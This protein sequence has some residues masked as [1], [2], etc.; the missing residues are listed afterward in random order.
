MALLWT[1]S[2]ALSPFC[3]GAEPREICATGATHDDNLP[4]AH[5]RRSRVTWAPK[6]TSPDRPRTAIAP[7]PSAPTASG[8]PT[9]TVFAVG[10]YTSAKCRTRVPSEAPAYRTVSAQGSIAHPQT[11]QPRLWQRMW[12]CSSRGA[13]HSRSTAPY[14]TCIPLFSAHCC[15]A[16]AIA[17]PSVPPDA[18]SPHPPT[19]R[20]RGL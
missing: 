18:R 17:G 1:V 20:L 9:P 15:V 13:Q 3:I 19:R 6:L 5:A 4:R 2:G 8:N 10:N 16:A 7:P 14:G 12:R 11:P